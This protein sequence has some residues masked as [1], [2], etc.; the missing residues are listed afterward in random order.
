MTTKYY[1]IKPGGTGAYGF[2]HDGIILAIKGKKIW[3]L[4][5]EWCGSGI[6]GEC[7][8]HHVDGKRKA[9]PKGA[10]KAIDISEKVEEKINAYFKEP[11]WGQTGMDLPIEEL[12]KLI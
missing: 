6:E 2:K 1:R 10:E 11:F 5:S 8:R 9:W 7:Y 3:I 12:L 4:T